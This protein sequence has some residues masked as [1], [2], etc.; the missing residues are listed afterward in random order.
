MYGAGLSPQPT[1][2]KEGG[3]ADCSLFARHPSQQ[4]DLPVMVALV[5]MQSR[6]GISNRAGQRRPAELFGNT[7]RQRFFS[8]PR[9]RGNQLALRIIE[10]AAQCGDVDML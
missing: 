6:E 3:S 10:Q 1:F 4:A 2:R 5:I 8:H 7:M 9:E